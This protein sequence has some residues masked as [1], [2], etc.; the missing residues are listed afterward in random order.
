[1]ATSLSG[2]SL[3]GVNEW[4]RKVDTVRC[5]EN[6]SAVVVKKILL[7]MKTQWWCVRGMVIKTFEALLKTFGAS[8]PLAHS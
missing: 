5:A 8:A 7:R 1:M 4:P 2:R 6:K 3:S